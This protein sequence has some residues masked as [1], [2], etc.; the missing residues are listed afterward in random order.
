ME[1]DS[2]P[3]DDFEVEE[4]LVLM[5]HSEYV[6]IEE[7]LMKKVAQ[8]VCSPHA[9]V[10]EKA[11][12]FW[13]NEALVSLLEL[14]SPAVMAI[15]LPALCR[16]SKDH[17]NNNVTVLVNNVIKKFTKIGPSLLEDLLAYFEADRQL[18]GEREGLKNKSRKEIKNYIKL[19]KQWPTQVNRS[20]S[21]PHRHS[22]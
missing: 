9:Q 1:D 17:W 12:S 19:N 21:H 2:E 22:C 18:D 15:M 10:A 6:K 11:L 13:N 20:Y 5:D 4:I 14:N 3:E 8:C 7:V 16:T